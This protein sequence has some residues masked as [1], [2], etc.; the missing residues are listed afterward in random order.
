[1]EVFEYV[2]AVALSS[3]KL[4]FSFIPFTSELPVTGYIQAH[5][6]LRSDFS[7]R[8]EFVLQPS[9]QSKVFE[10]LSP[11]YYYYMRVR[12]VD[13]DNVASDWQ[14]M[15]METQEQD[16]FSTEAPRKPLNFRGDRLTQVFQWDEPIEG[17]PDETGYVL[18]YSK[19]SGFANPVTITG[20]AADTV[21]YDLLASLQVST[22]F[23]FRLAAV[24]LNGY[25]PWSDVVTFVSL[26]LPELES[27][28]MGAQYTPSNTG[29]FLRGENGELVFRNGDLVVDDATERHQRDLITAWKGWNHFAPQ[30]GV[31]LEKYL[32]DTQ[33]AVGLTR[34]IRIEL[35]RD[36]QTV[37][38][39]RLGVGELIIEAKYD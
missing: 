38:A 21:L 35:E 23:Y 4:Q 7:L 32:L 14:L 31:G 3:T 5:I 39:V 28:Q 36:G 8:Q 11:S 25:S 18:Q 27:T 12:N 9:A 22:R 6:S 19:S 2:D 24:N 13:I 26:P 10:G 33:A 37:D 34:A 17:Y 20:I 16:G 15:G 1:M 30:F 29:D